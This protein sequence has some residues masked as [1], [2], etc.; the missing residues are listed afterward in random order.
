MIQQNMKRLWLIAGLV[1]AACFFC[2]C[3]QNHDTV[4]REILKMA[5]KRQ[6]LADFS[7]LIRE[8][9]ENQNL[10][11]DIRKQCVLLASVI[12]QKHI[13]QSRSVL[14]E[15]AVSEIIELLSDDAVGRV[16]PMEPVLVQVD[17]ALQYIRIMR[18]QQRVRARDK[19]FR[20]LQ[21]VFRECELQDGLLNEESLVELRGVYSR[22]SPDVLKKH[23]AQYIKL[24]NLWLSKDP[25][26][27]HPDL[28]DLLK[29]NIAEGCSR[30]RQ[31]G[32]EYCQVCGGNGIC[33]ICKGSGYKSMY[34]QIQF[35]SGGSWSYQ[36]GWRE[37][38]SRK[39]SGGEK[40]TECPKKCADCQGVGRILEVCCKCDGRKYL[41]NRKLLADL[42]TEQ[43]QQLDA[44]LSEFVVSSNREEDGS[45]Q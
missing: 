42:L 33:R 17:E 38:H 25:L 43:F 32:K 41:L 19:K 22:V 18:E 23:F 30:C 2:G 24:G 29:K 26:D 11:A 35:S 5:E 31:S 10:S 28:Q 16:M 45:R 44:L 9:T 20:Q 21:E 13:S 27:T 34:K 37:D 3:G 8:C 14:D 39:S 40:L 1:C 12:V 6:S 7:A 4:A 15:N 36:Q